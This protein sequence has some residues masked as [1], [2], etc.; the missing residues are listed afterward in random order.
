[1]W[2]LALLT[3]FTEYLCG[4]N[5]RVVHC[6]GAAPC[7]VQQLGAPR[8]GQMPRKS[9]R[10]KGHNI[11]AHALCA[12]P[13]TLGKIDLRRSCD[14]HLLPRPHSR[15]SFFVQPAYLNFNETQSAGQRTRDQIDLSDMGSDTAAQNT[16][17][18]QHQY[19]GGE[20]FTTPTAALRVAAAI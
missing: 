10:A 16:I 7:C 17:A 14:P 12:Q 8:I 13:G 11:E 1:M 15:D 6:L 4:I 5:V 2:A 3:D 9:F 20:K 18:F 19:Q